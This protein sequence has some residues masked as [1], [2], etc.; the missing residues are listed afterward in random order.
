MRLRA[1]GH[2]VR[3][4]QQR[5]ADPVAIGDDLGHRG[6]AVRDL[7]MVVAVG[8]IVHVGVD[9]AREQ[10]VE[11]RVERG[12]LQHAA[13]HVVPGE[14]GQVPEVEDE[15][16]AQ[17]DR[18]GKPASGRED[19]EDPIGSRPRVGQPVRNRLDHVD[20]FRARSGALV[21]S[22]LQQDDAM[23]YRVDIHTDETARRE[24]LEADVREG[25]HRASE[26]PAPKY[27]YD[28]AGSL[29]FERITELAGVLSDPHRGRPAGGNCA[30]VDRGNSSRPT[31]SR[32]GPAPPRRRAGS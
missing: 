3:R 23:R 9:P 14:G 13:A 12:P 5:L 18:L 31:S 22:S 24:R 21:A 29:L 11:G 19:L 17:R 27:F 26:V 16:V 20:S 2:R 32:S 1:R 28:R 7:R 8:R 25:P 15:R 10:L 4:S 6:P 30:R